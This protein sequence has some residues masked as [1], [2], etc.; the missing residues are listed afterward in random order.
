MGTLCDPGVWGHEHVVHGTS[1]GEVAGGL[2]GEEALEE[3]PQGASI[4]DLEG[5]LVGPSSFAQLR[6]KAYGHGGHGLDIPRQGWE[7]HINV[8]DGSGGVHVL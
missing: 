3:I 5:L 6:E 4:G 7:A 2:L 8:V 1:D